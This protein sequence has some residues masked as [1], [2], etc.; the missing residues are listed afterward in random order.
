MSKFDSPIKKRFLES[1]PVASL[2]HPDDNLAERC[3]FKFSYFTVPEGKTGFD[4]WS[5]ENLAAFIYKLKEYGKYPLIHWT[6]LRVGKSGTVLSIYKDFPKKS[7]FTP[8]KHVPHQ[9]Q[10]GRFRLDWAGRL[11]GFVV[12]PEYSNV[13]QASNSHKFD[14]NTF[15]VVFIDD[16]HEFYIGGEAK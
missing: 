12:P 7:A 4:S 1:I 9:A 3:K 14:C 10:W 11:C 16:N 6:R 15:Y 13:L 8:P 2:D 5:Q